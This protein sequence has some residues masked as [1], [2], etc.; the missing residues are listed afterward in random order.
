MTSQT[1]QFVKWQ[2]LRR[3]L[4]GA[5][6]ALLVA[7]WAP[8]AQA[9]TSAQFSNTASGA[10]ADLS[11]GTGSA[12]TRSFTVT[13]NVNITDVNLGVELSHTFRS[14]LRITLTSPAG[15][16]VAI[17]T[18]TGGIAANLN[19]LFDDS[20]ASAISAHPLLGD[21]ATGAGCQQAAVRLHRQLRGWR[22]AEP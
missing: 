20:A 21:S 3:W 1:E 11:C 8:A 15:T 14:E 18:N 22:H 13:A 10:I 5:L 2:T 17:M 16:T 4:A 12:L 6:A 9:Q 7:V 19:D